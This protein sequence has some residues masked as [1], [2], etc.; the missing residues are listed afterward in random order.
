M[1][2]LISIGD[3]IVDTFVFLPEAQILQKD[4]QRFLG[5]PFGAKVWVNPS[6][7]VVGGNAANNVVGAARLELKTAIYTNVG[8]KDEDE[9]DHRIISKFK[10]EKVSTRYIVETDEFT[11]DHHIVLDFKGERTILVHHQDWQY[12][13]PEL[14]PA[15][16]VYFSSVSQSFTKS[17]LVPQLERYLART[18]AKLMYS[19]GTQQ[20]RNGVKKFPK[21]LSLSEVFILNLE[22]VKKVLEIEESKKIDIKKLLK[23]LIDLGPRIVIIT[24][25]Q[26]G[27]FSFDGE[28]YYQIDSFP[29]K[30]L[31]MT[32]SGDAYATGVLAAT[33]Y[34][35]DLKEAMRWGAANG[36]AVVEQIGPQAGL[37]TYNQL[38]EKLKENSRIVA[39]EI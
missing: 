38:Q 34:M 17:N 6:D 16:W 36:A 1:F 37:L 32:G 39:K 4:G 28:S 20:L 29:A 18:G 7:S 14:E 2:D 25:G 22:E 30:L 33:F 15:R 5:L 23:G 24:N 27:S 35:K 10:K 31:E 9:W 13:L 11:S 3:T 12:N 8:N 26:E 19:P 21:L